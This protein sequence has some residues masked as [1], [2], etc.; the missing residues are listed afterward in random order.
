MK[1]AEIIPLLPGVFQRA[2]R[3]G[4]PMTALLAV[5]E[6]LHAPSEDVL[7]RLD[8]YFDPYRAP[9]AFVVFLAGWVDLDR[10][11]TSEA[12]EALD[13]ESIQSLDD[14]SSRSLDDES[15]RSL[16]DESSR[17][18]DDKSSRALFPGGLGY[19]RE[20]VAAATYLARWRGTA[21]G[22]IAFLET[23]TGVQGFAIDEHVLDGN[24][25]FRPF[26]I[27]INI[28]EA[29]RTYHQLIERIVEL[30]KPAYVTYELTFV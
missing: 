24:G 3:P 15:S 27:R 18:L 1:Q 6:S 9:D 12:Y 7:T 11:F 8:A 2:I 14:E 19:L 4:S 10:L 13:G 30:E 29:A 25:R 20:L 16:D 26:H 28:P 5:M 23:V 22:L 17:S 21:K